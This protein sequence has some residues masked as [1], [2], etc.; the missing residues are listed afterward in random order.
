MTGPVGGRRTGPPHLSGS[1]NRFSLPD[2]E[3]QSVSEKQFEVDSWKGLTY[4]HACWDA[5]ELGALRTSN[6]A[7][8][9]N[10]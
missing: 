10:S 8:K 7:T 5:K 4:V 1:S 9:V 6:V 3:A 2:A